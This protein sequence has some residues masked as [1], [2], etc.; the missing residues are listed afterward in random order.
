MRS[1][2]SSG[3]SY[4]AAPR[5]PAFV[6]ELQGAAPFQGAAFQGAA[7][8]GAAALRGALAL[9]GVAAFQGALALV[10]PPL[11]SGLAQLSLETM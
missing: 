5:A 1:K 9:Q 7:P 2:A 3:Q 10:P 11:A 4:A 6:S 8:H